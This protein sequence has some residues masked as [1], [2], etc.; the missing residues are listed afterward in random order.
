MEPGHRKGLAG[1][2]ILMTPQ[3]FRKHHGGP[4]L[5]C[6]RII[7]KDQGV[8]SVRHI[9]VCKIQRPLLVVR[10]L[11]VERAWNSGNL[12]LALDPTTLCEHVVVVGSCV[13]MPLLDFFPG[14][15]QQGVHLALTSEVSPVLAS[16]SSAVEPD[17]GKCLH[18]LL[19]ACLL[20]VHTVDLQGANICTD[21]IR[22]HH[23]VLLGV[24]LLLELIPRGAEH[25][26][27]R[28]PVGVEIHKGVIVGIDNRLK[29]VVLELIAGRTPIRI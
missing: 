13:D 6:L 1:K 11:E 8:H 15:G 29:A 21:A 9:G 26:A 16:A 2:R 3:L 12:H 28:T 20:E 7:P 22:I 4:D 14:K 17:G 19:L 10:G 23:R 5:I 18:L 24:Q 25:P 27:V